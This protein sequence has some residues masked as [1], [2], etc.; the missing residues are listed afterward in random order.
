MKTLEIEFFKIN[1]SY[2]N[3]HFPVGKPFSQR[4]LRFLIFFSLNLGTLLLDQATD[5]MI[6][7]GDTVGK[8]MI[9]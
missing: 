8:N 9:S 7:R 2:A 6:E 1:F 5:K 3:K 4:K